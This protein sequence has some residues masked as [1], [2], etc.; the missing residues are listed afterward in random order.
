MTRFQSQDEV[1]G[2]MSEALGE[3]GGGF[4][5]GMIVP[6]VSELV[7]KGVQTYQTQEKAKKATADDKARLDKA[8]AAD[9]AWA[10]AETTL[11]LAQASP[12]KDASKIAAAQVV[13]SGAF[14]QAVQSGVGL[15]PES[16]GKR[17]AAAQKAARDAASDAL[18]SPSDATRQARM[19]AWQKVA[20]VAAAGG[21]LGPGALAQRPTES[22]SFLTRYYA[23][24]PV[25][26]WGVGGVLVLTGG[27]LLLR[28]LRK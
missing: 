24:I 1:E 11:D 16:A 19:R 27:V 8:I 26:G 7:Q 17:A 21:G 22:G 5:Y 14:G 2:M 4:D 10:Q 13:Q 12:V 15:T 9:A 23:G 20:A 3:E 28:A 25:W 6:A 18:A